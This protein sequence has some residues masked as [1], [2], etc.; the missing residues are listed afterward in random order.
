MPTINVQIKE[1]EFI[2]AKEVGEKNQQLLSQMPREE[3]FKQQEVFSNI[4]NV[5]MKTENTDIINN[6][7][8][9]DDSFG[10]RDQI[11]VF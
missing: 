8:V 1:H 2:K 7:E 10:S 4:E 11:G 9:T 3:Y 6:T 5:K